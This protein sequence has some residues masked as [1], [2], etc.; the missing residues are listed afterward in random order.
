MQEPG[1]DFS[2]RFHL[3][4]KILAALPIPSKSRDTGS[5]LPQA[6]SEQQVEDKGRQGVGSVIG[7]HGCC[8]ARHSRPTKMDRKPDI[9]NFSDLFAAQN[10]H[11]VDYFA[12]IDI[13]A[14]DILALVG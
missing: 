2:S 6:A 3:K 10:P 12:W 13:V 14:W 4:F 5:L 1:V 9:G 8:D 7:K 11:Y